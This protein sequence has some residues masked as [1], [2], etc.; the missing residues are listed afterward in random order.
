MALKFVMYGMLNNTTD[1]GVGAA[2]HETYTASTGQKDFTLAGSYRVGTH[3]LDVYLN[4]VKQTIDKD[5]TE[6]NNKTVRF[7][8]ALDVTDDVMFQVLEVRN[9]SLHLEFT[10]TDLQQDFILPQ[11]YHP[12]MNSL[13]VFVDGNLKRLN[14]DYEEVNETAVR[15]L[16][17]LTAGAKVTFKEVM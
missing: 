7:S 16:T 12:N 14:D 10:A 9:T 8:E 5:Y 15:F 3:E 13:Q 11:S 2:L 4:G 6:L 1:V 17:P